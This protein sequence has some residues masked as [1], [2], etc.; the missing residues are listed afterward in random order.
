MAEVRKAAPEYTHV[1]ETIEH[2]AHTHCILKDK[3]CTHDNN[4]RSPL[5]A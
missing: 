1:R 5:A 2:D 4:N 3:G